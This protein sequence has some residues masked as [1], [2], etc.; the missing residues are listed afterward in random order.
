MQGQDG[1]GNILLMITDTAGGRG[2][3]RPQMFY[4]VA[5]GPKGSVGQQGPGGREELGHRVHALLDEIGPDSVQA[6]IG[7][8]EEMELHAAEVRAV[9]RI[10]VDGAL[11]DPQRC[12]AYIDVLLALRG[13]YPELPPETEGERPQAFQ[14][15]L[16]NM[17]QAE[18]EDSPQTFEPTEEERQRYAPEELQLEM[19]RRK[20]KLLA[21]MKLIGTLY[22]RRVLVVKVIDRVVRDLLGDD[23][24]VPEEPMVECACELLE[25][26]GSTL[27]ANDSDRALMGQFA[28]RL[29]ALRVLT[30]SDGHQV[31]SWRVK[32]RIQDLL[33]LRIK[34]WQRHLVKR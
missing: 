4:Y 10:F 23:E 21:N 6:A 26:I 7:R 33:D 17:C 30:G 2:G 9:I 16:L 20:D 15:V 31:Y 8:L 1:G 28:A 24:A 18:F 25:A 5:D 34:R 11:A 12:E 32:S 13:R 19:E 29:V 3:P 22:L 27:D 14:R